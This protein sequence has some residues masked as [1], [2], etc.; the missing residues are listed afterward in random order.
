[1]NSLLM[2]YND[3]LLDLPK[4][5]HKLNFHLLKV[6]SYPEESKIYIE[7]FPKGNNSITAE[8]VIRERWY[9]N[10]SD[11][12]VKDILRV[13]KF[14][15]LA[16][17]SGFL[18]LQNNVKLFGKNDWSWVVI[19]HLTLTDPLFRWFSCEFLFSLPRSSTF[20]REQL[21]RDLTNMMPEETRA[22]TRNTFAGKLIT[23]LKSLRMLK[24]HKN[25][26]KGALEFSYLGFYYLLYLLKSIDF[27]IDKFHQTSLFKGFFESQEEYLNALEKLKSQDYISL[28][29]FGGQPAIHLKQIDGVVYI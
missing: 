19:V 8:Q 1:M 9:S 12:R 5:A 23:A 4:I 14:R 6:S 29:W 15:F 10:R 28:A 27:D 24:G 26:N 3:S 2:Q 11:K 18:F 22:Y 21:S 17:D 16:F 25:I 13:F 20:T 7:R